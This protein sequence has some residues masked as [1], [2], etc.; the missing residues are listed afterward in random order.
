MHVLYVIDSL[1]RTGGAEQAVAATAPYLVNAGVRLDVAYFVPDDGLQPDLAAA[2]ARL[3]GVHRPNRRATATALRALIATR[4]PDLVHTTLFQADVIGRAA[5]AAARTPAVTSL[6]NSSYGPEHLAS[7]HLKPWKLRA[8][9][10]VDAVTARGAVR[11]HALTRHVADSMA[12]RLRLDRSRI[13]VIPR[14]RDPLVL[15]E[16]DDAR[17]KRVRAE[18]GVPDDAPM[19]L[20]A[21]RQQYQK[22]LDVLLTAWPRVCAEVPGARLLLAGCEGGETARLRGMADALA[23][24]GTDSG[25]GSG[26]GPGAAPVV[27]LGPR[28]DVFDLMAAADLLAVPSRWEGL[29]SAALEAMGVGVPLVASDVPALR[30]T[31]GSERNAVLVPPEDPAALGRALAAGLRDREGARQRAEAARERFL[32]HYTIEQVSARMVEFYRRALDSRRAR[33]S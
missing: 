21:A 5:A 16:A 24:G 29:G 27:F 10:G 2:G 8:A 6:V 11:F 17:R 19:V 13:E 9:Q 23:G 4:R 12:A 28:S 33:T 26:S 18:L 7:P 1:N 25:T 31:V 30:E 3:F 32:E 20:A 14:G 22:G 15:G